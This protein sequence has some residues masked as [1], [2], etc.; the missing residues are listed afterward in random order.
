MC[1]HASSESS[2]TSLK[3]NNMNA[4]WLLKAT[5]FFHVTIVMLIVTFACSYKIVLSFVH[6]FHFLVLIAFLVVVTNMET[7]Q[8]HLLH[9][10]KIHHHTLGLFQP[11]HL[12]P[13][14]MLQGEATS[15]LYWLVLIFSHFHT[16]HLT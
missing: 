6:S 4:C 7:Q 16:F 9:P 10:L 11:T 3:V 14:L 12:V 8:A 2:C 13:H 5:N 15:S 1:S